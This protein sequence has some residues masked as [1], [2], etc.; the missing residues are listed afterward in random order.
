[1]EEAAVRVENLVKVYPRGVRAL[2]GLSFTVNEGEI[3]GLVG[4]NG[5][6]KT[7]TLRILATLLRPTGG[8]ASVYGH[9]VVKESMAVRRLLSYLPE[10]ASAPREMKGVEFVEFIAK[11]RYRDPRD[12]ARVLEEAARIADLGRDMERKVKTYSKGMKR[13]LLLATVLAVRPRLA[14]LD[15]P[16]SG[17]DVEQSLRIRQIIKKYSRS[18]GVTVLLSSHNMLEVERLCDRIGIIIGGRIVE[19]GAPSELKEKYGAET[20]ED[21]FLAVTRGRGRG[22]PRPQ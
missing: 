7:T 3:Y 4:P 21:V 8:R 19:E 12:V 22:A 10:E 13:R 11:L 6:G 14:I 20:L 9:D 15:E 5:A 1:L 17:L 16:T 2:N 18:L